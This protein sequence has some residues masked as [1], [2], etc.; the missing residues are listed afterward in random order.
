MEKPQLIKDLG[1]MCPSETS[2]YKVRYG[3]YKCPFCST[4]FKARCQ[5][6]NRGQHKSCGCYFKIMVAEK[7]AIRSER[8][9][10][11]YTL[12]NSMNYRC[13]NPKAKDYENYGGKGITV[14]EEWKNDFFK[15]KEWLI[16]FGIKDGAIFGRIDKSGN[17]EPENLTW[18]DHKSV[19]SYSKLIRKSN[20]SGF[21]GVHNINRFKTGNVW[22]AEIRHNGKLKYIGAYKTKEDA[23][24]AY[25][26][27][28]TDNNL[29]HGLNLV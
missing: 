5:N 7:Y 19:L 15:F 8:R 29:A 3:I 17:F 20:K 2:R 21:V 25:N 28:I 10:K 11:I 12:W 16:A 4:E 22:R 26:K 24:L 14:Y 23:A 13:Y 6:I 9:G 1:M 18:M 27:Y